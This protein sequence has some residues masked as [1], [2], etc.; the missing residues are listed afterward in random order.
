MFGPVQSE[1]LL[2]ELDL[3]ES[4]FFEEEL[5]LE[6]LDDESLDEELDPFD[7]SLLSED[8]LEVE[9]E[10]D[11]DDDEPEDDPERESLR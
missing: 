8:E 10:V 6:E 3:V 11:P 9:L 4:L 1:E 2:D 7:E 5:S